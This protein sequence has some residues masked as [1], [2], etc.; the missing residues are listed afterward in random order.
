MTA[1]IKPPRDQRGFVVSVL[2]GL[3]LGC[4]IWVYAIVKVATVFGSAF[5]SLVR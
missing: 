1:E 5:A 3:G 4:M 2:I